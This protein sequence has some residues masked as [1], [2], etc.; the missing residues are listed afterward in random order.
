MSGTL[1]SPLASLLGVS[2]GVIDG[3]VGTIIGVSIPQ[4]FT[5]NETRL[6]NTFINIGITAQNRFLNTHEYYIQ[7]SNN[8][9]SFTQ[10][11]NNSGKTGAIVGCIGGDL[12]LR[13]INDT[14]IPQ[15]PNSQLGIIMDYYYTN[16]T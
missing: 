11:R 4:F 7:Q 8:V 16:T 15:Q 1:Q 9:N 6:P 5:R 12:V 14:A 13:C 10:Y 2:S 3:R